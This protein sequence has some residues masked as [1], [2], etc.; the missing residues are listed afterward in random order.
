ML[1]RVVLIGRLANDPELKYTPSGI[2][3]STF[4]LAVNRM[5]NAQGEREADFIPIVAWRQQAE[6]AANYLTKGRL[7]AVD[8]K[9][10]IRSWVAQDGTRR[11]NAEVI[12][13]NLRSLDRPKEHTDASRAGAVSEEAPAPAAEPA[14]DFEDPFAEE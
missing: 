9:L 7:V 8:G 6:F 2:A 3:V 1:N 4:T 14:G 5:P 11:K 10:Q 12:A 13:D